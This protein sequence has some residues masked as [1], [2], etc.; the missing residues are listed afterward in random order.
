MYLLS[1]NKIVI[2]TIFL[3]ISNCTLN[4][5]VKHHGVHYLDN[6]QYSMYNYAYGSCKNAHKISS[7][8]ISLPLHL[9]MTRDD[10]KKV[11]GEL[12]DILPKYDK[13]KS[14][15]LKSNTFYYL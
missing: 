3:L 5:V 2:I 7:E 1:M 9:H 6:T 8:L 10:V 13:H 12:A 4:K 14:I 15:L 11:V